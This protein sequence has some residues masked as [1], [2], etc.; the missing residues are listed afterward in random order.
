MLKILVKC[1]KIGNQVT[2]QSRGEK[3]KR[4][5][6]EDLPPF[7]FWGFYITFPFPG[8]IEHTPA[9]SIVDPGLQTKTGHILQI[10]T[11]VCSN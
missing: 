6:G 10:I 9:Q 4:G 11:F 3:K 2:K 1:S 7:Q 5:G 8:E